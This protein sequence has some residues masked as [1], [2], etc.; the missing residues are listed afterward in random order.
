MSVTMQPLRVPE[1]LVSRSLTCHSKETAEDHTACVGGVGVVLQVLGVAAAAQ[2]A[3]LPV[4][5]ASCT[6]VVTAATA[7]SCTT[8]AVYSAGQGTR[9]QSNQ[10]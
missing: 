5:S 7:T 8:G 3:G 2:E 6:T 4:W 9:V 10:G 1:C